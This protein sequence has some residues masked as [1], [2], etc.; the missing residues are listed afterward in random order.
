M[1]DIKDDGR[2]PTAERDSDNQ[3]NRTAQPPPQGN[4][5]S[6]RFQDGKSQPDA[7]TGGGNYEW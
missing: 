3:D 7:D 6:H 4:D 2:N 1:A 5:G